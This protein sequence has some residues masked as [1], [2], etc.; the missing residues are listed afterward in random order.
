[1]AV[2]PLL[3]QPNMHTVVWGGHRLQSYKGLCQTDD[4]VGESWEV[5]AVESSPCIVANGSKR[6]QS[7]IDVVEEWGSALLGEAVFKKYGGNH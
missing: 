6:G 5:S 7:L 4:P 3:F 2:Y 1:M